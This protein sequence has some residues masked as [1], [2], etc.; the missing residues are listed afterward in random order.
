MLLARIKPDNCFFFFP[1]E[2][3][4]VTFW[5]KDSVWFEIGKMI[6]LFRKFQNM[7]NENIGKRPFSA[8]Q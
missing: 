2:R 1:Q 5:V 8:L 4:K 7:K 3:I 6:A